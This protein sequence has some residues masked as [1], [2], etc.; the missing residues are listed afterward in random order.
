MA[1]GSP[2]GIRAT[3][4]GQS[5]LAGNACLREGGEH[6]LYPVRLCVICERDHRRSELI[7]SLVH[8]PVAHFRFLQEC[9]QL[10][11]GLFRSLLGEKV[12]AIESAPVHRVRLLAPIERTS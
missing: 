12:A 5:L 11:T 6:V 1:R 8:V 2:P 3:A 7:W 10:G 9:H 4:K